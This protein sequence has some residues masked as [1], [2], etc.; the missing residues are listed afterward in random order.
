MIRSIL[1][2]CLTLLAAGPVVRAERV[3][4]IGIGDVEP[5]LVEHAK[6]WAEEN[7][8]LRVDLLPAQKTAGATLDDIAAQAAKAAPSSDAHVVAIAMPPEGVTHHGMRTADGRSAVVNL[9][10]MT[11]DKPAPV[12]LEK[13][14]ERQTL[15][16][17][18]LM[19]GMETCVNPFCTLR[20]YDN[21]K[22]LDESGRNLCPPCL[23]KLQQ[24]ADAQHLDMNKKCPLYLGR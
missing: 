22:E 3:A 17:L 2:I 10:A 11:A 6:S 16:S 4:V 21:L 13:R 8:A 19:L 15:R 5:A 9:R 18:S 12:V 20:R 23:Q 14:V 7:L 24:K 1:V